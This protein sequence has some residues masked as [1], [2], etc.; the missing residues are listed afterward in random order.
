MESL[1]R[2]VTD[3]YVCLM[4]LVFP[5]WTGLDG[6]ARITRAKFAF[7]AA[8]TC[9]WAAALLCAAVRR[10]SLPR[11]PRCA[12]LAAAA[13]S[14]W[15]ALSALL[16]PYWPGTALG[17]NYD[18]LFTALLCAFCALGVATYGVMRERYVNLLA[19]SV[20]LCCALALLQLARL[21]PWGCTLR[22]YDYYGG[23][24][25][26]NGRFL[27]TLGNVNLLGAFL[28]LSCPA[29]AWA[30]LD[31][32]GRR[33][34]LLLPAAAGCALCALARCEGAL[35]GMGAAA[36]FGI[37]YYVK[38]SKP[39]LLPAALALAAAALISALACVYLFRRRTGRC[40]S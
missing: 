39:R 13:F 36:L 7:F 27:G 3:K 18:G 16:S 38:Q 32:R 23:G 29:L 34:W 9:I 4:L 6:Y 8:A 26:Y 15:A 30:A 12:A 14:A 5:L 25:E 1:E 20:S 19:V 40:G 31:G 2:Y 37:L 24:V 33:L 22:G 35:L 21:N 11:P 10:R 17:W 28:S